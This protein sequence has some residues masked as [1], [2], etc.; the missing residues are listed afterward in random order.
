MTTE[1]LRNML[2]RVGD[3]SATAD[4]RLK[5]TKWPNSLVVDGQQTMCPSALPC[6]PALHLLR[7]PLSLAR[8]CSALL[9]KALHSCS[10]I[11]M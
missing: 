6:H 11:T 10:L 3:D 1:I 8:G 4:E 7:L 2:Y 5:V 9:G